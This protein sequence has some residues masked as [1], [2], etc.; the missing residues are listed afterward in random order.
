[1]TASAGLMS[2]GGSRRVTA[3][4][5]LVLGY[6]DDWLGAPWR[7]PEVAVLVHG[8]AE[9]SRAW[10]GWVSHLASELRV[11]RVDL[12]GFG[13]SPVPE[14]DYDWSPPTVA[15]TLRRFLD[16]LGVE[17]AHLVGAKYGGTVAMQFAADYPERTRTLAVVSSPVRGRDTGGRV[18]LGSFAGA[19]R[20]GGVRAWAAATQR[21]RLGP[22]ASD[23][24]VAWWTEVLMGPTDA[25]VCIAATA[26][27]AEL[28]IE[29]VLSRITAPTLV[30]TTEQSGLQSV[31]TV[32]AYQARIPDSTLL[33]L[34]GRSYHV[35][36]VHPD[37]CARRVR[38][39]IRGAKAGRASCRA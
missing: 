16:A 2:R 1:V 19:I 17:A 33:V 37:E 15:A 10:T 38:D 27:A 22:E 32:R 5:G 26:A 4:P 36:A 11:L 18:D 30:I 29:P 31:E 24:Q 8:I 13:A 28:D 7:E 9:S 35:A 6:E 20:E 12:P 14:A 39:F 3:A 23:A 25:Q 34:P 21:A